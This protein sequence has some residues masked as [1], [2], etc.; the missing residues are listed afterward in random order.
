MK[1]EVQERLKRPK[2][3]VNIGLGVRKSVSTLNKLCCR[4][5]QACNIHLLYSSLFC[6]SS[7][8]YCYMSVMKELI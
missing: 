1:E 8:I 6:T 7:A 3:Q 2:R 5:P 4:I